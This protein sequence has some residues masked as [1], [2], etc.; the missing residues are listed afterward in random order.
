[1]TQKIKKKTTRQKKVQGATENNQYLSLTD[2]EE[3]AKDADRY[4]ALKVL[5]DSEG[6]QVLID[7]LISDV[8]LGVNQL[9]SYKDMSRDELVSVAARITTCLNTARAL[10]RAAENLE[11]ADEELED[12]LRA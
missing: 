5:H 1:M 10:S 9:E 3:V 4:H 7:T 12:R 11:Y 2:L 8:V 6:G